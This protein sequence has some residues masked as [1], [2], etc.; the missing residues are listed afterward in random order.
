[1][2]AWPVL[3][4]R[5]KHRALLLMLPASSAATA[6]TFGLVLWFSLE[7]HGHELGLAE[8]CAAVAAAAWLFPVALTA[9]PACPSDTS[10]ENLVEERTSVMT[11]SSS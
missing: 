5:R 6:I 1:M 9:R 11:T 8:R 4:A 3:A 7:L 10:R 2:S